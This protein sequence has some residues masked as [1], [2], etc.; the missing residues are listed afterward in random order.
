MATIQA[1]QGEILEKEKAEE[2][3]MEEDEGEEEV[4]SRA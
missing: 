4:R 2:E 1:V 3:G